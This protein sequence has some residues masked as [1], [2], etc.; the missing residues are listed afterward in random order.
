[1]TTHPFSALRALTVAV[2]A[3]GLAV[4][5]A[6]A[7]QART[8][9]HADPTGDVRSARLDVDVPTLEPAPRHHDGDIAKVR[10]SNGPVIGLRARF[11]DLKRPTGRRFDIL[12]V[13]T[14]EHVVRTIT[15]VSGSGGTHVTVERADYSDVACHG[16]AHSAD[17]DANVV[18][19]HVPRHCLSDP[20]WVRIG[21]IAATVTRDDQLLFIDDALRDHTASFEGVPVMSGRIWRR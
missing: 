3:A 10:L 1:M 17:L 13:V 4:A 19:I 5:G 12:R 2:C 11:D 7:A 15:V 21:Y 9:F 18:V 6:P 16:V 20:R 14:N 8:L